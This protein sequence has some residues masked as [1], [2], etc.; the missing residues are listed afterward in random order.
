M[1]TRAANVLTIAWVL[2]GTLAASLAPAAGADADAGKVTAAI[3]PVGELIVIADEAKYCAFVDLV[4]VAPSGDLMVVYNAGAHHLS[5]DLAIRKRMSAD[6]GR[7]WSAPVTVVPALNAGCGVRDPHVCQLPDGTLLL[8]YFS[9]PTTSGES[10]RVHV[11]RSTDAGRTWSEPITVDPGVPFVWMATS[12]KPLV[13]ADGT[14]LLPLYYRLRNDK[15]TVGIL[16]SDDKGATWRT[17]VTIQSDNEDGEMEMTEL[18]DGSI[19]ALIR[20]GQV[21]FS[22][23]K[24]RTWSKPEATVALHA[25]GLLVDGDSLLMNY[26][27]RGYGSAALGL[28]LDGGR[29]WPVTKELFGG[30]ADCAYGAILRTKPGSP[31]PYFTACY[32]PRQGS[33]KVVGTYFKVAR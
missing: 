10:C 22:K 27:S 23:D 14:I 31:A 28:S 3:E 12:G 15:G 29:T 33:I 9:H 5:P 13:L 17:L 2:A 32:A 30:G 20:P 6:D 18:A 19:A 24:G 26:R 25:A 16:R 4:R 1:P 8:N 21:A 7:T 11:I